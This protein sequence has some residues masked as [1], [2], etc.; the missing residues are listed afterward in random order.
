MARQGGMAIGMPVWIMIV[1]EGVKITLDS[2]SSRVYKEV[3][4][5]NNL[6][7]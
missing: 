6:L 1:V 4:I 7:T 5:Y 3:E 2:I